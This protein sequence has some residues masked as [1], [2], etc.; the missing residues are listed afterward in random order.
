MT[1][2]IVYQEEWEQ[3]LQDRLNKPTNW[4]EVC[5]VRYT[6]TRVIN[7]P[8]R[9]D[10]TVSTGYTRGSTYSFSDIAETNESITIN[11]TAVVAEV[12]DRADI[13]QSQFTSQMSIADL[14]AIKLQEQLEAAMLASH[15][16]FTDV[17]DDGSGNVVLSSTTALTVSATNIDDIIRAIIREVQKAN[18]WALAQRNGIFIIWRPQDWE[19]LVQFQQANGFNMADQ[20]LKNGG[21]IG[22]YYMGVY[23]Y[24]STSHTAGHIFA[25]VRSLFT[26]GIVPATYGKVNVIEDPAGASGGNISG[27]GINTRVDYAFK[28]WTNTKPMLFDLNVA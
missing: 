16:S 9:T 14:Q 21:E 22:V 23:H 4:K 20:A 28:A 25:G 11:Q 19:M 17:G 3:K 5:D 7:N 24:V 1:Q 8:Y 2:I 18:G 27:I 13:A 10:P 12:I 26:L 15:A 6:N